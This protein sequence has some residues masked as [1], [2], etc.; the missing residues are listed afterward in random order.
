MDCERS[1]ITTSIPDSVKVSVESDT[2]S[3]DGILLLTQFGGIS[4]EAS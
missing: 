1:I 2:V 3:E 4:K